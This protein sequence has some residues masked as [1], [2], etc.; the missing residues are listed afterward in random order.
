MR[1]L[2]LRIPCLLILTAIEGQL[3][4]VVVQ[5]LAQAGHIAMAKDSESAAADPLTLSIDLDELRR[6]P[7]HDGLG[8]G[9]RDGIFRGRHG[10]LRLIRR[11]KQWWSSMMSSIA[12]VSSLISLVRRHQ[13]NSWFWANDPAN[14]LSMCQV[15]RLHLERILP[16]ALRILQPVANG[17]SLKDAK[18]LKSASGLSLIHI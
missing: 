13:G 17:F 18:W 16:K 6:E 9:Q 3:L 7:S 15:L 8:R 1:T 4:A 12:Y 11:W 10:V 5:R 2:P 14:I